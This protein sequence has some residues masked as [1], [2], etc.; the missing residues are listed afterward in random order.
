MI[1]LVMFP[2][3]QTNHMNIFSSWDIVNSYYMAS[4]RGDSFER[5]KYKVKPPYRGHP[6]YR[7]PP[8]SGHSGADEILIKLS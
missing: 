7:T 3:L 6:L 4:T 1:V 5:K 2:Y 8:Y